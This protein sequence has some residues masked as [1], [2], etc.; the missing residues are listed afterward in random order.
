MFEPRTGEMTWKKKL[1]NLTSHT[2]ESTRSI[3][4]GIKRRT[5]KKSWS[6]LANSWALR[7]EKSSV[8]SSRKLRPWSMKVKTCFPFGLETRKSLSLLRSQAPSRKSTEHQMGALSIRRPGHWRSSSF[9]PIKGRYFSWRRLGIGFVCPLCKHDC[10]RQSY[11]TAMAPRTH[12][13]FG[14]YTTIGSS[15]PD[16]QVKKRKQHL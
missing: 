13:F 4:S 2:I 15:A 11:L 16:K 8:S 3:I 7:L 1:S 9:G 14:G 5:M 10:C 6:A 12:T